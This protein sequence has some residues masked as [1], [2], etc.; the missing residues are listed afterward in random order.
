ML[1]NI[2]KLINETTTQAILT[3]RLKVEDFESAT[4]LPATIKSSMLGMTMGK[5]GL[6]SPQ[7]L[8]D[9]VKN[10][11]SKN[12]VIENIDSVDEYNQEKF[13]ELVKYRTISGVKIPKDCKIFVIAKDIKKVINNIKA[14]CKI[15]D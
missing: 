14:Y 15:I 10:N 1:N 11:A 9:I 3:C 13:Y 4:V 2:S 8:Y 7:W 5:D 6:K 12:I